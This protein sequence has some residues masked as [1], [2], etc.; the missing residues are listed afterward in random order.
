MVFEWPITGVLW[1]KIILQGRKPKQNFYSGQTQKSHILQGS[2]T[3]LTLLIKRIF[4]KKNESSNLIMDLYKNEFIFRTKIKSSEC[5]NIKTEEVFNKKF[6][7]TNV[8]TKVKF[9]LTGL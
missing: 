4:R 9:V 1:K 3:L 8:V 5:L 6:E 2:K 7:R